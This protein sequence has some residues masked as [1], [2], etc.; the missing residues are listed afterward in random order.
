MGILRLIGIGLGWGTLLIVIGAA[1][2]GLIVYARLNNE[3]QKHVLAELQKRYPELDIHVGSA[4]IAENRGL[5][6]KDIEFSVPQ[7]AG[8]PRK[9]L[10]IGELFIECP[11]TL[12][13]LYQKNP[14]ISR[15]VMKDPLLRASRAADGTFSELQLFS[16]GRDLTFL[17]PEGGKPVLIEIENGLLLYDDARQP[18][19]PLRLSGISLAV[20]PEI[21]EQ[22]QRIAVKGTAD[23]D[24]CRRI[25]LEALYLPE[26]EQ[27][28]CTANCRQ[29]E[30]S[31]DL[32]QYLPP[33][34][35]F[36]KRPL[37][38]GRFDFH[39]SAASDPLADRGYRF[40][41]GGTLTHGRIDFPNID[42]TLTEL[43]TRFEITDGRIVIDKLTGSGDSARFTASYVQEGLT[44]FGDPQQRAELTFNVRDLRFDEELIKALSP[45]LNNETKRLLAQYEYEGM[46]DLH[47]QLLCQ[48]GRWHPKNLSMRIS[49][50][51]F[52][53]RTFPY[54]LDRMTGSLLVD[55][56]AALHINLTSKQEA[57]F[58][59]VISG[60][61]SNI[62]EDAAGTVEII[63][64]DV[65]ID[66]KLLRALPLSAQQVVYSLQP[67]GKIKARLLLEL[68]PGDAPL[69]RQFDIALDHVSLRYDHFPYPLRDVTGFLHC[70]G[71]AWEFRDVLGINGTAV[72]K[73][74]GQLRPIGGVYNTAQEFVLHISAEELPLDDQLIQSLLNSDQRQLLQSLK[75]NGKVNLSAQIQYRTDDK[76]LNLNF[77]AFPRP[78]LSIYPDRFPYKI[79][80]VAGKIQ[81][82]N[83]RVF[84]E[85]LTG[86]HR[87]TK[88]HS[89][90]D[91][92][93]DVEGQSVLLLSPLNIDQLQA[94]R[95]LL[96]ALPKHLQD[97][98][99][100][101]QITNPFNLSGGIEY[102]QTAQGEHAA[103]WNVRCIL[104]QNSTK[105]GLPLDNMFGIVRLTGYSIGEQLRLD[106][107][108]N[109]DSLMVSGMYI[110]DVRG[111]FTFDNKRLWLGAAE[112]RLTPEA[113]HR[114]LTGKFCGG[115]I[116]T[117]GLVVLDNG[118]SYNINA[119]LVGAD[120]EKVSQALEPTSQKTSGTLNCTNVHLKGIGAK[121]ETVSGTGT[122][123]LRDANIYGAPAMVRLL[124]E[125]RIKETDPNAGMFS[126]VDT[127]FRLSGLQMFIDSVFFEGGLISMH[128]DGMMRLD[129]RHVDL[130]MKTRLGNR[131]SQ[132]P[133]ISDI[134]GGAGDQ[135]VQLR[136]TGPLAD[137]TVTR[138]VVPE[139][140]KAFQ[141]IQ[142]EEA[143]LPQPAPRN[144]FAPSKMF[145]WNPL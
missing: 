29:F 114:P 47:A 143:V 54:R 10:Y 120:L 72:V 112:N 117:D 134:I 73:G 33:Q 55:D 13:S 14:R 11:V 107:E 116:L 40:A 142:P 81:Y 94:D 61:Y 119:N 24:F 133:V 70:N 104:H 36:E 136:I 19:P 74:G 99:E 26:T 37:F 91:C 132:I 123:Q 32:W 48:D 109:L 8:K 87:N 35:H 5:T 97:F 140:Q 105:L 12:Q 21:Q 22:T 111:P 83:G 31:D 92:R 135:L 144:R 46:T 118:I 68:P 77:Q 115:T 7:S 89:G 71:D 65:P 76:Q 49:E 28:Q 86:T 16:R 3:V 52:S 69:K 57:P 66:S 85:T 93:F 101:M 42:R 27:W 82:E 60:H 18:V 131:R 84:A 20:T 15:I 100:S 124:R 110:T 34:P 98:L 2:G 139:I 39:V 96:D 75:A 128:G 79:E 44:Y 62:F 90:L 126:S 102:R 129:N 78:G 23:G 125:L 17:F 141:Q 58:P 67:S 41:L 130:T 137:P 95:E 51:G 64:E 53:H 88:L 1:V 63:G 106:G 145:S 108:L 113:A 9:L 80:D 43:S 30:W 4:Q 50:V 45:F 127:N 38:Q 59:T 103:R 25:D 122:I 56:T 138:V 121:W 6:V